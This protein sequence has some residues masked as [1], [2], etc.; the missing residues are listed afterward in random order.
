MKRSSSVQLNCFSPLVM[1]ATFIVEVGSALYL[2]FRYRMTRT[3]QLI[4]AMLGFLAVFQLA[5]Y[6]VCEGAFYLSSLDWARIGYASITILPALGIHLGLE[7][8]KKKNMPLLFAAYGSAATFMTFFLFVG[9]GM[10]TQQ[11]LGNYVIFQIASYAILPFG[12]YYNGWLV[13]GTALAWKAHYEITT[14]AHRKALV[15]LVFGYLS[16]M[17]P[18]LTV[19]LINPATLDGI[20]SIMC[21]FAVLMALT[22]L[23]K[24]SPLVLEDTVA[25]KPAPEK[26]VR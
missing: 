21:G 13:V 5:E 26:A 4:V 14:I 2:L 25:K 9:H 20:P 12:F 7:I 11:C 22:L 3:A 1:L 10:Q 23:F 6:M 17:V 19:Y 16:F 18:T 24:I 8:A 15:W